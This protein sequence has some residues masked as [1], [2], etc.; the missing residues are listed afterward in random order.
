MKRDLTSHEFLEDALT[1]L[2]SEKRFKQDDL[3]TVLAG[4]FGSDNGASYVEISTA[5]NLLERK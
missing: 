3:I 2:L 1:R 4:N 5:K